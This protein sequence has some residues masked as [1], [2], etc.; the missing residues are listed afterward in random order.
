MLKLTKY[1]DKVVLSRPWLML[2]LLFLV[3]AGLAV[4]ARKFRLDASADSLIL[5]NDKDL[6]YSRIIGNRYQTADFLIITYTPDNDLFAS[7]SLATLGRLRDELKQLDRISS[8]VTILDAP[9]LSNPPVP[10]KKLKA[11][12]KTLESPD[13]DMI[14]AQK[15]LRES[16]IYRNLLLSEDMQS[17]AIQINLEP[18]KPFNK[19]KRRRSELLEKEHDLEITAEEQEELAEVEAEYFSSKRRLD[20]IRHEGICKVREIMEGY[21]NDGTLYLGGLPMIADDM[22][23]FVKKDL[24]VF[25]LG[26]MVFLI[27]TLGIIFRR[28]RWVAL[29]MLCCG[30]SVVAMLGFLG[31]FG[32]EVTVVSSNFISLQLIVT[33]ALTIHLI[34]RYSELHAEKPDADNRDLAKETVRTIFKPCLYTT[35]TTI[36]GFSSLMFCDILPVINFGWM[37]AMGLAVSL[38]VTFLLFPAVLMISGKISL[39]ER[40]RSVPPVTTFFAKLTSKHAGLIWGTSIVV[41]VATVI[42]ISMLKVENSFID[43]F[44]ESTEIYKGM[45]FIDAN[46]GGTT[47]LDVIVDLEPESSD[48]TEEPVSTEEAEEDDFFDDFEEFDDAENDER[49]WFTK[50]KLETVARIHDYLDS[51]P[52]TGK[53]LSLSTMVRVARTLNDGKDLDSFDLTFLFDQLPESFR[54]TILKPYVSV[55][56]G[57]ARI[58]VRLK[59]SYKGLRRNV[60]LKQVRSDLTEAMNLEEGQGKLA[61][62]MI[63][64]NNMLQSLFS[65]QIKTIGATVILLMAMFLILFRSVKIAFIAILPNLLS[66]FAVLG[67]MGLF[68]IPLDMMTIT[69]VAISVGIAV[70]DTIHYIHRFRHEMETDHNYM[71]SMFRCHGSI[72]N[73]MYY[74]SVTIIIGFSILSL[75]NFIPTVLFG[76]LTG[77]AMAMALTAA[78][79]L[80]PRLIIMLKP[81]GPDAG[82]VRE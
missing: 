16:P 62:M 43:Y 47:P 7:N 1:Y 51:L 13:V 75:S 44:K 82:T 69:I 34:V 11:N 67:V 54:N 49:Y 65:S 20:K 30:Y 17:T 72:G 71:N 27:L 21:K 24:K 64:Y 2:L 3:L 22:I 42:G 76:L 12:I 6:K 77:F 52:E 70:D 8:V 50:E 66:C 59:D 46:M 32:W 58:S 40:K 55:E 23:S 15:E 41:T 18:D 73:A 19:L 79:T 29:P 10:L 74:T 35:L 48:V 80:L 38:V 37:M 4:G 57:E 68:G 14:L 31:I 25:G 28:L 60:F 5:E 45:A 26:L 53:V 81:F 33:M 61:G 78:L 56:N 36:A 9:L 39:V 63:L